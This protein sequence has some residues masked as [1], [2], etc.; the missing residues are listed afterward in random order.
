[1]QSTSM[2]LVLAPLAD[3]QSGMADTQGFGSRMGQNDS[4]SQDE[5]ISWHPELSAQS[6]ALSWG[7]SLSS[8]LQGCRNGRDNLKRAKREGE[9]SG[10][11]VGGTARAQALDVMQPSQLAVVLQG[12]PLVNILMVLNALVLL[13]L[14]APRVR[15][16]IGRSIGQERIKVL[17]GV[18]VADC[19]ANLSMKLTAESFVR[20]AGTPSFACFPGGVPLHISVGFERNKHRVER[21]QYCAESLP[22]IRLPAHAGWHACRAEYQVAAAERPGSG[23]AHPDRVN[24]C[25]LALTRSAKPSEKAR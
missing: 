13:W 8:S 12:L 4:K 22:D 2:M 25:K 6:S 1:M 16:D 21:D 9:P 24:V 7:R 5:A 20:T 3:G 19:L 15:P 14:P 18:H 10:R 23:W 11:A 17:V